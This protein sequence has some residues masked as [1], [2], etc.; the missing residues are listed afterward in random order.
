MSDLFWQYL[1]LF[2]NRGLFI[3]G[4]T[5]RFSQQMRAQAFIIFRLDKKTTKVHLS[6][7][8]MLQPSKHLK[9]GHY[10]PTSETSFSFAGGSIVAL[11][12][13]LAGFSTSQSTS[14]SARHRPASETPFKW[15]A[16]D[17]TTL[18]AGLVVVDLSH[19][20]NTLL[21]VT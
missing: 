4:V 16:N 13:M 10:R 1:L 9:S 7:A 20:C 17:G 2:W 21:H 6:E 5:S 12:W 18:C 14:I 3:V 19:T 8:D 11:A 15:R